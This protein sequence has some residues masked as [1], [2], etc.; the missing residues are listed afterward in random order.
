[1]RKFVGF[2]AMVLLLFG[3][4]GCTPPMPPE[5]RIAQEEQS[6]QCVDGDT[7]ISYPESIS[8]I[9]ADYSDA[10]SSACSGMTLSVVKK[11]EVPQL[12][13]SSGALA[14]E[15]F[16][17][18]PFAVDAAVIVVNE[19]D[20]SALNLDLKTTSDIFD[21]SIT[22]WNDPAIAKLNPDSELPAVAISVFPEV[23]SEALAAIKQWAKDLGV[24]FTGSLLKPTPLFK[25]TQADKLKDNQIAILP[26]SVNSV[27]G[28]V[29]ASVV[30]DAKHLSDA[31]PAES[32]NITSAST[33]WVSKVTATSVTV[34]VNSNQKP[35]A[36]EGSDVAPV[37][38][39]A[40]YPVN[41][42]LCGTDNLITR[43]AARFMLRQDSQG[44]LGSSNL[45]A[46]PEPVRIA[47]IQPVSKGL[48]K[49]KITPPAN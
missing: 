49:V 1:M 44:S 24:A 47:A 36:P 43:A 15:P 20:L 9:S 26:Y 38:Y 17:T 14:C 22:M 10:I 5:L 27:E 46:L 19:P 33:Q 13:I 4:T 21:G 25:V 37:P 2:T 23:Q 11:K 29:T 3:L 7:K 30:R 6:F 28:F 35:V 41:L 32:S 45:L 42:G 12:D 40:I 8:D 34:K 18:V 16:L 48:P 39:D 31:A